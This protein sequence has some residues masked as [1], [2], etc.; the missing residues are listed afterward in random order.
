MTFITSDDGFVSVQN[1]NSLLDEVPYNWNY[2][3][4]LGGAINTINLATSASSVD[5]IYNGY[6]IEINIGTGYGQVR[7]I[8]DYDGTTKIATILSP[9]STYPDNTSQYVIYRNSGIVQ[10]SAINTII[11]DGSTGSTVDNVYNGCFIKILS[12]SGKSQIRLIIKYEGTTK[13]ATIDT[14]WG[15]EPDASSTYSIFGESGSTTNSTS[16]SIT[17]STDK[18]IGSSNDAYNGLYIEIISSTGNSQSVGQIRKITNYVESTRVATVDDW[19]STPTGIITYNIFG[20]WGGT[21]ED[22][23]EYSM[24]TY[25]LVL[26]TVTVEEKAIIASDL[27]QT[28]TGNLKRSKYVEVAIGQSSVHTLSVVSNYCRFKLIGQGTR[29]GDLTN[30]IPSGFQVVYHRSKS[31]HLT[32]YANEVVTSSNDTELTRSIVMGVDSVGLFEN[33]T[34]DSRRALNV[35]VQSPRTAFGELSVSQATPVVQLQYTYGILPSLIYTHEVGDATIT[36]EDAMLILSTANTVGDRAIVQSKSIIK[37]EPGQGVLARFTGVFT[38]GVENT[39]QMI[40]I[41]DA[42]NGYFFGFNGPEFGILHRRGGKIEIQSL[43]ITNAATGDD[44][45][46]ITLNGASIDIAVVD[47]DSIPEIVTKI[48]D[49][50]FLNVG[51]G[52]YTSTCVDVIHFHAVVAESRGGTYSFGA[53]TTGVAASFTQQTT[54]NAPTDNWIKQSNWNVDKAD[55]ARYLPVLIPT[56]GNVFQIRF[57]YLGFGNISFGIEN[58]VDGLFAP[59]HEISYTNANIVPSLSQ[60][61]LPLYAEV[62]SNTAATV[63]VKSASMAGYVE[64]TVRHLGP[65][66]S[67]SHT[68]TSAISAQEVVLLFAIPNITINSIYNRVRFVIHSIS[69]GNNE[70]AG[71]ATAMFKGYKNPGL[72]YPGN[73]VLTLSDVSS[74][75][76]YMKYATPTAYNTNNGVRIDPTHTGEHLF[77]FNVGSRGSSSYTFSKD[78][79]I[80]LTPEDNLVV[81]GQFLS[82]SGILGVSISW[83]EDF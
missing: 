41:G 35:N 22:V 26:N 2:G 55:N 11:L 31:K 3:T 8:S 37:Y 33:V 79:E 30:D 51:G 24:L 77:T 9:W 69:F 13:T 39:H 17:L 16:T 15:I 21:Y 67:I 63:S 14:R 81:T 72:L 61:T 76:S 56:N 12:G 80:I 5:D 73:G 4:A 66:F 64:G 6:I 65:Q 53:A 57:Q 36:A 40:G 28:P 74:G 18:I 58:P 49:T 48:N 23:H 10:S 44:N 50:S 34:I 52:W 62:H 70:S 29:I 46:T 43:Q 47:G 78:N 75:K 45:I 25:M 38:P 27:A 7:A 19:D 68:S 82:K 83:T 32:T 54:G 60:S 1:S 20:G 59:I 42:S 71:T